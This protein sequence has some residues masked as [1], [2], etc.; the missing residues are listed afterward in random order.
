MVQ[1]LKGLDVLVKDPDS[2]PSIHMGDSQSFITPVLGDPT[3][4]SDLFMNTIHTGK[5]LECL[6]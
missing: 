1:K 5:T 2:A 3:P 4:S 6:K